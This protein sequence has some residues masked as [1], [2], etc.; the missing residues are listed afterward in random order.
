MSS[1]RCSTARKGSDG[2]D[3]STFI[4][5]VVEDIIIEPSLSG[6]DRT[7]QFPQW[8]RPDQQNCTCRLRWKIVSSKKLSKK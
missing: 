4:L 8:V 5:R 7:P 2:P 1:S 3:G 6:S